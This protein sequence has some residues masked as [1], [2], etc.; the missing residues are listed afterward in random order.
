MACGY[1]SLPSAS[2]DDEI[3]S[4]PIVESVSKLAIPSSTALVPHSKSAN[5]KIVI[6]GEWIPSSD[7]EE[8]ETRV[9]TVPES[10][11]PCDN[12]SGPSDG[13]NLAECIADLP[14]SILLEPPANVL[15]S[16]LHQIKTRNTSV[17]LSRAVPSLRE[18]GPRID[19]RDCSWWSDFVI[20]KCNLARKQM[21]PVS[22]VSM[23][24]GI[25]SIASGF[26][27]LSYAAPYA[28]Q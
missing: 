25:C 2:E 19:H 9:I 6:A 26:K 17:P 13:N 28:A 1:D 11:M 16:V 21:R 18:S 14:V 15:A 7:D 4:S 24:T 8:S 12:F 10:P 23:R 27:A 3:I 5:Q 22:T 20:G